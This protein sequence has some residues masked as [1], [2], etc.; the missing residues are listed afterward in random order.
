M[1]GRSTV[2]GEPFQEAP[3]LRTVWAKTEGRRCLYL[4]DERCD[5]VEPVKLYLDHL[6]ALEKSPNTLENYCRHL[7]RYFAFLEG[8]QVDWCSAKPDDLVHFIHSWPPKRVIRRV[9]VL[10]RPSIRC[11]ARAPPLS[12]IQSA[13]LLAFLRPSSTIQSIQ[14]S[15]NRSDRSAKLLHDRLRPIRPPDQTKRFSQRCPNRP[16]QRARQGT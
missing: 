1:A 3:M 12:S 4:I 11:S 2:Q 15:R 10:S 7:A 5:F 13:R 8:E 6:T 16:L 9:A 14:T